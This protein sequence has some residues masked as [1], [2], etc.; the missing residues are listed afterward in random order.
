MVESIQT[1]FSNYTLSPEKRLSSPNK[2]KFSQILKENINKVNNLQKNADK[3]T[4]D[5]ALGKTD[6]IHQVTVATEKAR[7]ALDLTTSLQG[8]VLDAYEEIMRIQV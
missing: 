2:N 3:L 5:F 4:E 1:N 6:N 7:L 8:R